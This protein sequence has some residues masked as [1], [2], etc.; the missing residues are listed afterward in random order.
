MLRRTITIEISWRNRKLEKTVASARTA[1]AAFGVDGFKVLRRRLAALAAAPTL[2]DL[3]GTP[4]NLHPLRGDRGGQ[5]ALNLAGG[6][7]LV[8]EVD[9]DPLPVLADGGLDRAHVTKVRILE[10][11]DYHG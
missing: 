4:G 10:V 9:E 6:S 3:E 7:R 1:Q 2:G 11:V 8:F 5:F